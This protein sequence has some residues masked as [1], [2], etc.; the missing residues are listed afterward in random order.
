MLVGVGA[1]LAYLVVVSVSL[2]T[3]LPDL[4]EG[5][6]GVEYTN[7]VVRPLLSI[8]TNITLNKI[9]FLV[10]WG[11]A[12]LTTYFVIEYIV[13]LLRNLRSA[14]HD[15]QQT[16]EGII[17]RPTMR[18][19]FISALWRAG[20]LLF[21]IPLL[22]IA[23]PTLLGQLSALAPKAVL[24]HLGAGTTLLHLGTLAL[25]V[26]L[27]SHGVVVFLRLFAERMRLGADDPL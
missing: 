20:V 16:A 3:A 25:M 4:F 24:G 9:L 6:W 14:N 18:S 26:M 17:R 2:G 7:H 8:F 13:M 1:V 11:L 21:F 27:F 22:V 5:Q 15:I 23:L 19:F 12:G 10:T